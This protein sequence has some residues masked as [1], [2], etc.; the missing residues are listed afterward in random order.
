MVNPDGRCQVA[1]I[2]EDD[3]IRGIAENKLV[4]QRRRN[5]GRQTSHQAYAGPLKGGL[6]GRKTSVVGPQRNGRRGLPGIVNVADRSANL[7]AEIV[8]Y[9]DQFLAPI[10]CLRWR[11]VKETRIR[12]CAAVRE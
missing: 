7:V 8:V 1:E 3:V 4:Q 9:T 12:V 2:V 10:R 5:G 6:D 11:G